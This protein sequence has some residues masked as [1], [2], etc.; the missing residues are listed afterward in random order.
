MSAYAREI[1]PESLNI[2]LRLEGKQNKNFPREQAYYLFCYIA[3]KGN[4]KT[5]ISIQQVYFVIKT[6]QLK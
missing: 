3:K 4:K 1:V 6:L 5:F 2:S